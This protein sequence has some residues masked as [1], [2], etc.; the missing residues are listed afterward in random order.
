M[1]TLSRVV[2]EARRRRVF[3][4]AGLYVVGAW[5]LLQVAD[6]ALGSLDLPDSLLR[7]F[8]IAAFV[9][10]PF[11]LVF[12]W[13][14]D[15]TADGIRR[16]PRSDVAPPEDIQ[17]RIPDYVIIGAL[18]VIVAVVAAG[19]FDRARQ[20]D[21]LT[22]PYDPYAIAVLPLENL[23]GDKDQEYFSAGV[24]DALIAD[25][26]KISALRVVSR[27]STTRLDRSMA[28]PQ[29]G[30]SLGVR[31]IIEGSV[32]R[33]GSRVRI[34]I[35][36]VDAALDAQIWAANYEREYKSVL[37][38][39][40][41]IARSIARAI[42]V[43]LTDEE[44]N[45]LSVSESI[46]PDVYD[47]Y[48]RGMYLLNQSDNRIRRRGIKIL[49][50]LVDEEKADARV[51]AALAYGYAVLGHSPYPEGMYPASRI[52]AERALEMDDSIAEVY[53][54]LGM[55]EMY[56]EWNYDAAEAQLQHALELNPNLTG[57]VYHYA[58]LMELW[59]HSD[60]ALP[61]GDRTVALDP[62]SSFMFGNLADQYRNAGR[63]DEARRIADEA[64]ELN[65][66]NANAIRVKGL[67]IAL[68]GDY[69]S[70][71]AILESIK[72]HPFWR[73]D[74]GVVLAM[75]GQE[76]KAREFLAGI[77]KIPRNVFALI[78]VNAALGES[79]EAF[80]W[81]TVAKE[82]KLP[83]YPWF[84]TWFPEVR[85]LRN[86]PRM[87]MLAAELNLTEAL[88]RARASGR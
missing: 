48:L 70:A 82:V 38:L 58:W 27:T 11:A 87:D 13:Y 4:T 76:Q 63:L 12:G 84:I 35:Q 72:E 61:L 40:A 36:L 33:E 7:F 25:L 2:A 15:V 65:P 17:M 32:T 37:T 18:A 1:G 30:R 19:L 60:K 59:Q 66:Q 75:A 55:H 34:I 20:A 10:F 5:V 69:D 56:Y 74:Y 71:L 67:S 77:E 50:A 79:D 6:L 44:E 8:W 16:T 29:I 31:N 85:T 23:S 9:I 42:N 47:R 86:D 51:Y 41:E 39:Q 46:D 28:I 62:L 14:F 53:L 83:W 3:R 21:E 52:A 64:I 57:A 73:F 43:R 78:M 68:Q 22:G 49:E 26:S 45:R 24:H 88:A 81:M 80:H 54:A